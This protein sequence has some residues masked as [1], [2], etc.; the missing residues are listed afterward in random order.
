MEPRRQR[1]GE[2]KF[3]LT[4]NPLPLKY[5]SA[6]GKQIWGETV[7]GWQDWADKHGGR[8]WGEEERDIHSWEWGSKSTSESELKWEPKMGK[9]SLTF[10]CQKEARLQSRGQGPASQQPLS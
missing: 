7:R 9:C 6:K 8:G 4:G 3:I 10:M 5:C 1:K 2:A